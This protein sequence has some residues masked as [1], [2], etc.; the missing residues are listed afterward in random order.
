MSVAVPGELMGY[1]EA[2]NRFGNANISWHDILQPTIEMCLEGI[3]VTRSMAAA[4]ES[5]E[6]EIRADPAMK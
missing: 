4:I 3:P 5:K 1:L 2:K 6:K